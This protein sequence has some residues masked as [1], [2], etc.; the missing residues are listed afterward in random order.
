MPMNQIQN[1][2]GRLLKERCGEFAFEELPL[3]ENDVFEIES[4]RDKLVIRGATPCVQACGLN[5]YL[6]NYCSAHIS[7]QGNQ[8]DLPCPLPTVRFI[9]V[10]SPWK[11]RC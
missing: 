9:R 6:R 5:H 10:A 11:I 4:S 3:A 7:W 8:L 1:L 2:A